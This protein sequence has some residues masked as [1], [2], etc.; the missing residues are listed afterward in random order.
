M[1]LGPLKEDDI[2]KV[3]TIYTL[4]SEIAL[5]KDKCRVPR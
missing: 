5:P 2:N 4:R 3:Y 1:L